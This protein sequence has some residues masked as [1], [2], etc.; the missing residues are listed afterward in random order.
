ML[1]LLAPCPPRLPP[2]RCRT[3]QSR[4]HRCS[5]LHLHHRLLQLLPPACELLRLAAQRWGLQAAHQGLPPPPPPPQPVHRRLRP[6]LAHH[7]RCLDSS[8][9]P[10]RAARPL[11]RRRPAESR[12]PAPPAPSCCPRSPTRSPQSSAAAISQEHESPGRIVPPP[13]R[14]G[15]GTHATA[16]PHFMLFAPFPISVSQP[17]Q[18]VCC[19]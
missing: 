2:A 7:W 17:Q 11:S 15:G 4:H 3:R 6:L 10:A 16:M 14:C 5:G 8:R 18:R 19:M 1:A 13:W 12:W 9:L